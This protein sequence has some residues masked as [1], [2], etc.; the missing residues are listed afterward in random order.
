LTCGSTR[1]SATVRKNSTLD[2]LIVLMGE[3]SESDQRVVMATAEALARR[4]TTGD[5]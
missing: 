1:L 5:E 3:L 4:G 2:R